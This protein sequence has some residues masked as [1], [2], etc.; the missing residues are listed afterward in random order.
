[1]SVFNCDL[2]GGIYAE[3]EWG[4]LLEDSRS[5]VC[6]HGRC[7]F[8]WDG[9][10]HGRCHDDG[11]TLDHTKYFQQSAASHRCRVLHFGRALRIGRFAFCPRFA[12]R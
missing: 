2:S 12:F 3:Y 6:R 11:F 9:H 7:N 5:N 10:S 8:D 4:L 1:M